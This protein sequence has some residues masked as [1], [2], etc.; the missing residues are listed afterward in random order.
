[1]AIVKLLLF[2]C[3]L[4]LVFVFGWY[5]Y[6]WLNKKIINSYNLASILSYAGLL[7]AINILLLFGGI[8]ALLKTYEYLFG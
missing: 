6:K 2:G 4:L 8:L 7:I 3:I 5:S 1:M